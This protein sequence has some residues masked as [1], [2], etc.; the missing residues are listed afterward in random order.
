MSLF[1]R[2][3]YSRMLAVLFSA[4]TG[5]VFVVV[6]VAQ[7]GHAQEVSSFEGPRPQWSS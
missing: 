3:S 7:R 6:G 4:V 5:L 1:M 2:N